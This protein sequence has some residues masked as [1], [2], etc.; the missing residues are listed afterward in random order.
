V[1]IS[2]YPF[3]L[4]LTILTNNIGRLITIL[5]TIPAMEIIER[6]EENFM[7]TIPSP[8][9]IQKNP[10][11]RRNAKSRDFLFCRIVFLVFAK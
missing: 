9:N 11:F 1:A 10:G 8:K 2:V 7:L 6:M 5:N 3:R 4:L